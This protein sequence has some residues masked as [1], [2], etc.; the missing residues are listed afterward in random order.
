MSISSKLKLS[1]ACRGESS[2]LEGILITDSLAY[3]AASYGECARYRIQGKTGGIMFKKILI[4]IGSLIA[5]ILIFVIIAGIIVM[6][7]VDKAFIASQ[8][9]QALHR[10]VYIEKIESA[11]SPSFRELR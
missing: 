1:A 4:T 11:F 2:I 7:K 8:I 3:P 10:Q 5:A 6:I 9:A